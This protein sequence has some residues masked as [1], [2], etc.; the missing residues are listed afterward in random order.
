MIQEVLPG[1]TLPHNQD[2]ERS[3]LHF[4]LRGA[5]EGDL[6]RTTPWRCAAHTRQLLLNTMRGRTATLRESRADGND[7]D[8]PSPEIRAE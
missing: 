7:A 2:A 8:G 1:K 4:C 3:L 5:A 6:G